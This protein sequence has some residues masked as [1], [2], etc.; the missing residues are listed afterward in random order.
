ERHFQEAVPQE[1]VRSL[2][3]ERVKQKEQPVD[4]EQRI[5]ERRN[6]LRNQ[7]RQVQQEYEKQFKQLYTRAVGLYR[8]GS[9]EE[10]KALFLQIE[11]MKP[12]YK[13]ASSYLKKSEAKIR[14]GLQRKSQHSVVLQPKEIKARNSVVDEAL[15]DLEQ[16]L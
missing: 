6:E 1:T 9:Y 16:K 11:Q 7:R 4:W 15:D 2:P 5:Q 10:A 12:G 3:K 13:K 8:S 14:K